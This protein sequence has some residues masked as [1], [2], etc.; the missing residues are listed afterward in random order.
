MGEVFDEGVSTLGGIPENERAVRDPVR[1]SLQRVARPLT[2]LVVEGQDAAEME[3]IAALA[4]H[5]HRLLRVSTFE[6]ATRALTAQRSDLLVLGSDSLGGQRLDLLRRLG[7]ELPPLP[8][9]LLYQSDV[10][11]MSLESSTAAASGCPV[12]CLGPHQTVPLHWLVVDLHRRA[13]L[14][15]EN[16]RLAQSLRR[17]TAELE[18]ARVRALEHRQHLL[19]QERLNSVLELMGATGQRLNQPLS[20]LLG[21]AELLLAQVRGGE[22]TLARLAHQ[23][24]ESAQEIEA[25]I[26]RLLA[27][28]RHRLQG[29]TNG[30]Y[31]VDHGRDHTRVLAGVSGEEE[32]AAVGRCLG[33]AAGRFEVVWGHSATEVL[34]RLSAERFDVALLSTRL[35]EVGVTELLQEIARSPRP[36]PCIVLGHL[37][38]EEITGEALQR[39][40]VDCLVWPLLS[41]ELLTQSIQHALRMA[42]IERTLENVED[43]LRSR[44]ALDPWT[45]LSTPV[46]LQAVLAEEF[47]RSRR[48][49]RPMTVAVFELDNWPVLS[50]RIGPEQTQA[51]IQTL[52]HAM[53]Q[54]ARQSDCLAHLRDGRF[55]AIFPETD[56]TSGALAIQRLGEQAQRRV[57]QEKGEAVGS[58]VTFSAGLCDIAA[59]PLADDGEELLRRATAALRAAQRRGIG[60][61]AAWSA[62][63][64]SPAPAEIK[65]G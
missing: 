57:T 40:A 31:L 14:E 39:G 15:R 10:E 53:A 45:G 56:P 30:E 35:R 28:H 33:P 6:E 23:V 32:R 22:G 21:S 64:E 12:E 19:I 29:Q 47:E 7:K 36:V 59:P 51:L 8:V 38:E 50:E 48:H 26:R 2:L 3:A 27:I 43:Q 44:A 61:A 9:I 13:M 49:R 5:G 46:R 52:G 17:R 63:I 4:S 25:I 11:L 24:V 65:S 60:S 16:R 41:A 20:A 55:A 58:R 34:N 1:A 54:R 62:E 42:E 37:S 18:S